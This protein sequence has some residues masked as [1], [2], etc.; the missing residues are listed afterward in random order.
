MSAGQLLG[1]FVLPRVEHGYAGNGDYVGFPLYV[2]VHKHADGVEVSIY[3]EAMPAHISGLPYVDDD[4]LGM[5]RL[6][7]ERRRQRQESSEACASNEK[8]H[9]GAVAS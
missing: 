8:G 2:E 9:R 4:K 5:A 3:Q 7:E 1:R 6:S